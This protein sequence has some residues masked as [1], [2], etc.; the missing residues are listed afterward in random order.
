LLSIGRLSLEHFSMHE[1]C[2]Y[3]FVATFAE[4]DFKCPVIYVIVFLI[5]NPFTHTIPAISDDFSIIELNLPKILYFVLLSSHGKY[6]SP[7]K[8]GVTSAKI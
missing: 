6:L 2:F 3:F 1:C 4:Y 7:F 5:E 8:I